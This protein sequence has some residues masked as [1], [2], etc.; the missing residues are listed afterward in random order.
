MFFKKMP[1]VSDRFLRKCPHFTKLKNI[2]E[3][4]FLK[5]GFNGV[6]EFK[7]NTIS[8]NI[9]TNLP[10][11]NKDFEENADLTISLKMLSKIDL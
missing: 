6:T 11:I 7:E 5:K 3:N 8:N 1:T 2:L 10:T 9:K 4:V